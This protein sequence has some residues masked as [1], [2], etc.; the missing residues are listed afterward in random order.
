MP[1][2]SCIQALTNPHELRG[3]S[4]FSQILFKFIDSAESEEDDSLLIDIG[5]HDAAY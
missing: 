5:S 3:N 2:T 4:G 1:H